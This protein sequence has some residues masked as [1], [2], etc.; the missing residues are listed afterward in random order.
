MTALVAI[1]SCDIN[2]VVTVSPDAVGVEGSS[3]YLFAGEKL[4]LEDLLYAMLLESANDAAAAIAIAVGGSID[5]F[6]EMMNA[7]AQKLGLTDTH[8]TNPHGLDD[9]EHYTTAFELAKIASVAMKNEV[10]RTIVSTRKATVPQN[11]GEGARVLFN[12]NK[13]L[14]VYEGAIGIKT[15]YT[16]VSGRCLVSAA[17]REGLRLVCVTLAC[18]ND[19][20]DHT[21]LLD[22]GFSAYWRYSPATPTLTIP[23]V[24]GEVRQMALV[25]ESAIALTIPRELA[26]RVECTAEYPRFLFGGF[27]RHKPVGRL[28]YRLNGVEIGRIPLL[29]ATACAREEPLSLWAR[30]KRIFIK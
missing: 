28:V 6:S 30:I 13:L 20:R 29:T 23:V 25:P 24:G 22:W 1:E 12:H 3:I 26:D 8:F 2:T 19:W 17:E 7:K 18:P 14:G 5:G 4:S 27:A 11:N 9:P 16:K 21:A 10:F 15:G